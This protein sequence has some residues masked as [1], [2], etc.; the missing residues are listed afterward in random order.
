MAD[1][2]PQQAGRLWQNILKQFGQNPAT[3]WI[4]VAVAALGVILLLTG[5]D[6]GT[7]FQGK[8]PQDTTRQ[9]EVNQ[10][11]NGVVDA[12]LANELAQTLERIEGAGR[13]QVKISLKSQSRKIWERQVRE[14]KR[15]SQEQNTMTT[16]DEVNNELVFA[17]T[18]DGYDQPVLK[19]ELAPVV[20][21][22]IVV[23][24]G[25]RDV[26]IKG[27]L[28]DAVTTILGIPAHRVMVFPGN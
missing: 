8:S 1:N 13:V 5:N 12:H 20:E 16:E 4:L 24:E 7:N 18:R 3:S 14:S 19:E 2:E 27:L 26:R 15:T 25:A 9:I 17:K 10:S 11:S 22:V 21:G 6:K 23:A 28:I